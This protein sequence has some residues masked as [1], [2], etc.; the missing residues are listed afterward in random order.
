M[1]AETVNA[2][3]DLIHPEPTSFFRKYVWSYDHKVV[4][5]QYLW[6]SLLFMTLGGSLA[7]LLRWQI[8]YPN[9]PVPFW[10]MLLKGH[11]VFDASGA[12]SPDGYLQLTTMHGLIMVFFVIIPL[13]VSAFGNFLIP[14]H[15]G[16]RD[17]AFPVLN[18]LSYWLYLPAGLLMIASFFMVKGAGEAGWTGYPPLSDVAGAVAPVWGMNLVL[19]ALFLAGFSSI[20]GGINFLTTVIRMRAPGMTWS[21]LPLTT[22]AQFITAIFQVLA[23]PMLAAA[24]AMLFFDRVFHT[25]FFLP[26]GLVIGQSE[27]VNTGGG[28][29]LLWQHIFW[30]YAH[31]AVYILILPSMGFASD[32]LAAF[33]RK[34]VFGYRAMVI[35]LVAIMGLGFVVWGHHM[36]VSGLNPIMGMAFM[37]STVFI[38]LPSGVK[39]FN[40]MGTLWGGAIRLEP[41]MLYA[42]SFVSMFIIGGL[43]GIFM[44]A[45][46]VDIYIHDTYFII[47]HFHYVV[48]GA[49]LFAVFAATTYWF[50]KM[51][52]RMMNRKLCYLHWGLT[53]LFFNM[54]FF[55]M[56]F[57]GEA[58]HMRRLMTSTGYEF[59]NPM[60][61]WNEFITL[62]AFALGLSQ[63]VFTYNFIY[64]V[65]FGDPA[66]ANPW[67]SATLEWTV[68]AT[69]PHYNFKVIPTVYRGPHEYSSPE[70]A[71]ADW[72]AQN[73]PPK[74][75]AH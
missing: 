50:P 39:V 44:A 30:F 15:I 24:G 12:I 2:V 31:P 52:G 22:W 29:P 20:L 27:P 10:G 14:L 21:R 17:V 43:S 28:Y 9:Q 58:G 71:P 64:S 25:S 61:P 69:V 48:F 70:A 36:F 75:A 18:A 42:I 40:W 49:T 4:A 53:F 59:L 56:H 51:F 72:I 8:A 74:G 13:I 37:V 3:V 16:A 19:I 65:F 41:P 7:M 57:L 55:P 33:S 66:P 73:A 11:F 35:S 60:A 47:A 1:S 62:S 38:A 67:E 34:P 23:T 63:I 5:K 6:T 68:P 26:H 54:A 46:P 45:S 32:I